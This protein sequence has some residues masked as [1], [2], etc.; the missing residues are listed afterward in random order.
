MRKRVKKAPIREQIYDI[1]KNDIMDRKYSPGEHLSIASISK[2]LDVS[3]SPVREAISMLERDGLV[4]T[5][6]NA[7]STVVSLSDEKLSLIAEAIVG[8]LLGSFEIV[9]RTNK[10]DTLVEMLQQTLKEQIKHVD[11]ESEQDYALYSIKFEASFIRCCENSYITRQYSAIEDLFYLVV[12]YD[13]W[14]IDTNRKFAV[15]EHQKILGSIMDGDFE[16]T[17]R[18]LYDHYN[19]FQKK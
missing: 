18:L 16:K 13:H 14:Y 9:Q 17:K 3:N 6:P 7:G 11:D 10:V 2:E 19:R 1:I 4:E 12:L 15:V 8:M 5:Y